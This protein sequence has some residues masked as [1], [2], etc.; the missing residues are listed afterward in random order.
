MLELLNL[1]G[2]YVGMCSLGGWEKPRSCLDKIVT[3]KNILPLAEIVLNSSFLW[4]SQYYLC[5]PGILSTSKLDAHV[6]KIYSLAQTK[7][8]ELHL[9]NLLATEFYI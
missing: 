1:R 3:G 6:G 7:T 8:P 9:I 4:Q 5:C 2:D